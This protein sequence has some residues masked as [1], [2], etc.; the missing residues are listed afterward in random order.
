MLCRL[1]NTPELWVF[2]LTSIKKLSHSET[3][4]RTKTS[5]KHSEH[6][7]DRLACSFS[8]HLVV[9]TTRQDERAPVTTRGSVIGRWHRE[10]GLKTIS[11]LHARPRGAPSSGSQLSNLME[12]RRVSEGNYW[13]TYA[14]LLTRLTRR[15]TNQLRGR[16]QAAAMG[17]YDTSAWR[18]R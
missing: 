14:P 9:K 7:F 4:S 5:F 12:T 2:T 15:V 3:F 6:F 11:C 1:K 8:A 18:A 16:A 13:E 17:N 10:I